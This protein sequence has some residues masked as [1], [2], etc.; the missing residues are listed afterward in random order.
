MLSSLRA[1]KGEKLTCTAS[2][3]G[4]LGDGAAVTVEDR[5]KRNRHGLE[6]DS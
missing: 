3:A 5:V 1:K 6:L 2:Q 4:E